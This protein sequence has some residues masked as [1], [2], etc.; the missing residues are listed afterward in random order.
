MDPL[1]FRII[2]NSRIRASNFENSI[3]RDS[4]LARARKLKRRDLD[5]GPG[6]ES[7]NG[8]PQLNGGRPR[9]PSTS[10]PSV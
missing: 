5:G 8:S 6:A 7:F 2:A 10:W 4:N 9:P 3:F 1:K